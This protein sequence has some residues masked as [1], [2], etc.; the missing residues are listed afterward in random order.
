LIVTATAAESSNGSTAS[1]ARAFNLTVNNVPPILTI[2]SAPTSGVQ[3]QTLT[4]TMAAQDASPVDKATGFTYLVNWG[5][6]TPVETVQ[7]DPSSGHGP[8]DDHI[9]THSGNFT[10][11]I[12]AIDKDGGVSSPKTVQIFIHAAVLQADP[13]DPSKTDLVVSGTDQDDH[14][15]ILPDHDGVDVVVNGVKEGPYNPTGR[16]IVHGYAGDDDIQV[17]P[18]ITIS[19]WLYGDGGNDVLRSGGGADVLLGGAGDDLLDGR[20]GRDLLIGGSGADRIIGNGDADILIAGFTA[21][22]DNVQA[23]SAVMAEWT[24][25][26]SYDQRVADL[27]GS[28]DGH[29][30]N[31]TIFLRADGVGRTVFDD[32]S[33]DRL[34]GRQ[35]LDWFFAN[36]DHGTLD[37]IIGLQRGET[38]EDII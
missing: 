32:G 10:V 13:I 20:A 24:S 33:A 14:I 3:G 31:G 26:R 16:I 9:Y 27:S 37:Q 8:S 4:V 22:D 28:G 11:Q 1:T 18:D 38:I 21:F 25:G 7:S 34:A 5:D 6:G 35:A 36:L 30:L 15:Q 17:S 2:M 23:L 19:A 29:G 12:V